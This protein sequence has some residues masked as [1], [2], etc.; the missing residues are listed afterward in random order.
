M[1][2]KKLHERSWLGQLASIATICTIL[3]SPLFMVLIYAADQRFDEKYATDK[4]LEVTRKEFTEMA[5]DIR[6]VVY[7]NTEKMETVTHSVDGLTLAV[8]DMQIAKLE[9]RISM[10]ERIKVRKEHRGN[11]GWTRHDAE[12]LYEKKYQLADLVSQRSRV[13]QRVIAYQ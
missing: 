8:L 4:A 7:A 10:L 12:G 3:I 6:R 13:F 11:N 9:A 5:T 1:P 2:I